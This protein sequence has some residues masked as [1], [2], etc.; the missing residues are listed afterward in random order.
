MEYPACFPN[1]AR[2]PFLRFKFPHPVFFF[3]PFLPQRNSRCSHLQLLQRPPALTTSVHSSPSPDPMAASSSSPLFSPSSDKRFWNTL[4][5]H[6]D[7]ILEGRRRRSENT[8]QDDGSEVESKKTGRSK[9]MKEDALLLMRGFDSISHTLSALSNN[10]DNA[11]QGA[12]SLAEPPTLTELL[13]ANN[14]KNSETQQDDSRECSKGKEE[15][16]EGITGLKRKLETEDDHISVGEGINDG[17][18]KAN[19]SNKL[20]KAKNLAVS[21]AKKAGAMARELKSIKSDM[22]FVQERC[23]LLE[24]ENRRLRD[25][26]PSGIRPEEDDLMRLQMEA[27]LAEK[28]RL[29]NENANLTRENQCLNQLVEYHQLT[30]QDLSASYEQLV[31]GM[32]LDFS[33]PDCSQEDDDNRNNVDDEAGCPAPRSNILDVSTS[34]DKYFEEEQ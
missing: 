8:S 25:G 2:E 31:R 4:N 1:V 20:Q 14:T 22:Y 34:L 24:E 7:S 28:S 18:P 26:F 12:R 17:G 3:S 5:G 11:L 27:L 32:G 33:S 29:A 16:K 13:Q 30:N 19:T 6:V 10:I 23:A 21:M 15:E 9:R